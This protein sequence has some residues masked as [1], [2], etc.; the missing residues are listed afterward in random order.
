M[1]ALDL[2]AEA[3]FLLGLAAFAFAWGYMVGWR[4]AAAI[5]TSWTRDADPD[6][7]GG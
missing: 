5:A 4:R 3:A 2:A 6:K 1:T 7:N